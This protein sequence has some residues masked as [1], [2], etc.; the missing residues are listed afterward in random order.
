MHVRLH[1]LICSRYDGTSLFVCQYNL[2]ILFAALKGKGTADIYIIFVSSYI[3]KHSTAKA[4]F[5]NL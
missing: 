2:S 5:M 4:V 3:V 1:V